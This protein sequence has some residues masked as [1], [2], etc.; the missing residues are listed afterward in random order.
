MEDALHEITFMCLFS[1]LPLD[2]LIPHHP[3]IMNFR[4][5]LEK[6]VLSRQLFKEV[7]R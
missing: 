3:T 2:K 4:Y 6:Q 5:L 7:K 1:D